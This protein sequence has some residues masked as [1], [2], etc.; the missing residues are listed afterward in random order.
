MNVSD[1]RRQET[2]SQNAKPLFCKNCGHKITPG[3]MFCPQCGTPSGAAGQEPQETQREAVRSQESS[4]G[5]RQKKP[6]KA[7]SAG[8]AALL[9]IC[10]AVFILFSGRSRE[11]SDTASGFNKEMY[12]GFN[13]S[14][15][16]VNELEK[17]YNT[18]YEDEKKALDPYILAYME[19]YDE[20]GEIKEEF[21]SLVG[22]TE[23][24]YQAVNTFAPD[25]KH[26]AAKEAADQ[27]ADTPLEAYMVEQGIGAVLSDSEFGRDIRSLIEAAGLGLM[28]DIEIREL[29]K[30]REA[31]HDIML[32]VTSEG[33][34]AL[35]R[36]S[37]T[38]GQMLDQ[39]AWNSGYTAADKALAERMA[40]IEEQ[41]TTTLEDYW[42]EDTEKV[43]QTYLIRENYDGRMDALNEKKQQWDQNLYQWR[44]DFLQQAGVEDAD[45]I[46][47]IYSI[48]NEN[49]YD[50]KLVL[51]YFGISRKEYEKL[52]E[53]HDSDDLSDIIQ[54]EKG[55]DAWDGLTEYI[56][57]KKS[58]AGSVYGQYIY[59]IIDK[60]GTVS[61]SFLVARNDFHASMNADG[62]C[63]I[64]LDDTLKDKLDYDVEHKFDDA[65]KA[66]VIMDKECRLLFQNDEKKADDGSRSTYSDITPSGN[67][68]RKT[69][70]SDYEHGDYQVLEYV[71]PDGTS[72]KLFEGGYISMDKLV[73]ETGDLMDLFCIEG[74]G[75]SDYYKYEY[76]YA[77]DD[78]T[79]TSGVLDLANGELITWEEYEK[80]ISAQTGRLQ[81]TEID[82]SE[83]GIEGD[84]KG[85]RLNEDYVLY[86]NTIYDMSGKTAAELTDGRGIKNILY[87]GGRYWIVTESEWFYILDDSFQKAAEPVE[88]PEDSEHQLTAYGLL[89]AGY[90]E[91]EEGISHGYTHLYDESGTMTVLSETS[92]NLDVKGFLLDGGESGCINLNT[93]KGVLLS[94]PEEPVSLSLH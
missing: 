40:V 9:V 18:A 80:R 23:D 12:E 85:T 91:D 67:V 83:L 3:G 70:L 59:S 4:S 69:F 41:N 42:S 29:K 58:E 90:A 10:C 64:W 28:Q 38:V 79:C 55:N 26:V 53:K 17:S 1:A 89:A 25:L 35:V 44:S 65:C 20:Y 19:G 27:Y 45:D 2:G 37:G 75:I 93:Q 50:E 88:L 5:N 68:Y 6:F 43:F 63:S 94:T 22:I 82:M 86:G 39:I 92:K 74:Q 8:A 11:S 71:Q 78:S 16:Q 81:H 47:W 54:E 51:D 72:K 36:S 84:E 46:L 87:A 49:G 15:K 60:D 56:E 66:H 31:R 7:L 62:M 24:F 14:K 48:K 76:G 77:D 33:D 21:E 61:G 32:Y 57:A 73:A 52:K 34:Y 30:K 13:F